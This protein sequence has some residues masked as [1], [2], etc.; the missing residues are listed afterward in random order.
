MNNL[1]KWFLALLAALSIFAPERTWALPSCTCAR[2]ND[3]ND[4]GC[5][6]TPGG[7][8]SLN[9]GVN[10]AG[11]NNATCL[12]CPPPNGTP[13][14]GLDSSDITT[15]AVGMP[16]WWVDEPYINLHIVDEPL[17]YTTSSG[18]KMAFQWFYKQ[19][20]TLPGYDQIPDMIN[21]YGWGDRTFQ[22]VAA[23][24]VYQMRCYG[25]TNG[26]FSGMTNAAWANNWMLNIVYW[27]EQWESNYHN[28]YDLPPPGNPYV[29]DFEALVFF[30]DGGVD[31]FT[32][33]DGNQSLN[34][35]TQTSDPTSHIQ[36]SIPSGGNALTNIFAPD[37]NGIYW[38]NPT[39]GLVLTYPDGSKDFFG[40]GW[41]A[42][43]GGY[44]GLSANSTASAL[45]TQ[46]IDPQGRVT[47]LGYRS[48][49]FTNSCSGPGNSP[50]AVF[51][52]TYL[53][54]PD[55]RTSTFVYNSNTGSPWQLQEM[56]DP[57]GRKATFSYDTC[58]GWISGITNANGMANSFNYETGSNGW[59]SSM[60]TPYGTNSF[61]YEQVGESDATN[62]FQ[63]R[64]LYVTEPDGASQLFCYI[65]KTTNSIETNATAPTVSGWVFD[66][67][68]DGGADDALYHRNSFYWDRHQTTAL[69][70]NISEYL[71]GNL[72]LAITNLSS[73]L[74]NLQKGRMQHWLLDTDGIS[75]TET[76]SSERDPS[77]DAGG[78]IEGNRT[79]YAYTNL[80]P[81]DVLTTPQIGCIAQ[82]LPGG[83]NQYT[84]YSYYFTGL[85]E[86]NVQSYST[87][88]GAI[89]QLT[90]SF[91]YA[92]NGVDLTGVANSMGQYVNIGYNGN[93][94]P[95]SITN[96]LNQVTTLAYDSGTYNLT[97][98]SLYT[99]QTIGL[100]YYAS[101]TAFLDQITL[102]P[103]NKVTT[104]AAYSGPL[105]QI[106]HVTGTALP[107]LWQ[108]NTWDNL[109]RLTG[110]TYQDG[111]TISN[112][113]TFLDLS[114]H[115]D[116]L[117]NW[118]YYTHDGLQ[119]LTS[120]TNARG[121]LTQFTWCNCGAL[122]SISNALG[123]IT[124]L[125]YNNQELLTN[126]D[127][128][129]TSSMNWQYDLI[130][131]VT[132]SFDGSGNSLQF[133]YNNQSLVT[134]IS[135]SYGQVMG[136]YYDALRRPLTVTNANNVVVTNTFDLLNRITNRAWTG[137][138]TENFGY[139]TNG[140]IAYTNQ[141]GQWT[142]FGRNGA[143]RM[144][145]LTN[146][147]QTNLFT[148][149]ALDQLNSL[150]NG[151]NHTTTWGYNQYG[152]LTSKTNALGTSIM[153][154]SYDADGHV[155]N[156]SM[157]GTTT[158]YTYN[159][160][161]NLKTIIYPQLTIS[162]QY[163]A[164]NELTNMTDGVGTTKFTY[165]AIGQLQSETGP[166]TSDTVSLG[167]NQGHRTSLSLTQPSGSWSQSYAYDSEWRMTNLASPAGIFGYSYATPNPSSALIS[168][169]TLP[170]W[171]SI[172]N[173][174]DSLARLT[175]TAL[176]NYWG[177]TLDGYVYGLDLLGLRT[178]ITRNLGLTTNTVSI[179]YDGIGEITSWTGKESSGTLR[180]NEQLAYAY[181]AAGNLHTRTND[182][183]IQTFNVDPLNQLSN[184][185]RT[186]PL[187]VTGATPVPATNVT[188]NTVAAQTYGDF[189]FAGTNNNLAN[190]ANT[191]TN[192][193]QN[194][195]GLSATNLLTLNLPATVTLQYDANGN[196]TN[197]GTRSF[198]FDAE[199]RLTNVTIAAQSQTVF[200][201]DGLS[202]RRITTNYTWTGSAWMPTNA[203]RYVYD[204]PLVIQERDSNNNPQ[205]TYT[206]GLDLS[207]SR[208]GAGGI[209]GL[210]ARTD[211]NGS[212][213]YHADGNGNI[214]ALMDGNQ[215]IVARYRY[216][217]FGK[218]LGRWGSM[219][220]ANHYRYSSKE[221]DPSGLYYYGFRF[222]EPNYQRWLN[223][224]PSGE[225]GGINLYEAFFNSPLRFVDRNGR[226]NIYNMG[227]GNNAPPSMT[228]SQP[229]G[230]G[231][232]TAQYN[233]GGLGD[234]LLLMAAAALA[235]TAIAAAIR[236]PNAALIA[237]QLIDEARHNSEQANKK[238]PCPW[239]ASPGNQ[240]MIAGL[241]QIPKGLEKQFDVHGF[242]DFV[243]GEENSSFFNVSVDEDNGNVFLTPRNIGTGEN[244][245]TFYDSIKSVIED[246]PLEE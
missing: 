226:D 7:A 102:Q 174:Y 135:N 129:D 191:F 235:E 188:I 119:H 70:A 112:I 63:Q 35:P 217:A 111:T 194:I 86:N 243:V 137:G 64:G 89:G 216:D 153:T 79:W 26:N 115:K 96:T 218:L 65:H 171:A 49:S 166:W 241:R 150:T 68:T 56:D 62:A 97:N 202:R 33:N 181:D 28:F 110:T 175:N 109:N 38:G 204:G 206:R 47:Q 238:K 84:T 203:V 95:V 196:L 21:P 141:D 182:A 154:Y 23:N 91:Y 46:R 75:V 149:D 208:Q 138:G 185:T 80:A 207:L 246:F 88:N 118:T 120:I 225:F 193:A 44:N 227:A 173:N 107:D 162:N 104:I 55:G 190:G 39:N 189:T 60:I 168:G 177:H 125:N 101:P 10:N 161:G 59:V 200:V 4:H 134:A 121:N 30:P 221:Q 90:T 183:L 123:N 82:I 230:G 155:T 127:F 57:F 213:Y 195:Y 214:T 48:V 108:T 103:E 237:A 66:D 186:G 43:P 106:I 52:L 231:P 184:V 228:F 53:V 16:R 170:N 61:Y 40:L 87:P 50:Y 99:G 116:R 146:A 224:D 164:I 151:L 73:S 117:G 139:A 167:Y 31:Y 176:L 105:P 152:W 131:R 113:Y 232:T 192:I 94:E 156:R 133:T 205:V 172:A 41:W 42:G 81:A 223:R 2:F 45:L 18:Q 210:L 14:T 245:N 6:K 78:A 130:G 198:Y 229:T 98:V 93:H 236:S 211:T 234:P 222:Y 158:G 92:A 27:D 77:P 32:L 197:D 9:F 15:G 159:A 147:L 163:D 114:A 124:Y 179:G 169:I 142:H 178:N 51:L 29:N 157:I 242:K 220:D 136:V 72:G 201:Y 239:K 140:L 219:A 233:G 148:Y 132:N 58:T 215:N 13:L 83:S 19:R 144:T 20:Y 165:T 71:T 244:V 69:S 5:R 76:L 240:P 54:D 24:Y 145:A 22:G 212:T 180:H 17:S 126:V 128:P 8:G 187:T 67:G 85:V 25:S 209:G 122:T 34:S 36:L 199:N 12:T 1:I 37:G 100:I 74:S 3:F 143:L 160:V 11:G